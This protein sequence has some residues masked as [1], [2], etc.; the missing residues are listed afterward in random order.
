[1]QK[2]F[3]CM[4]F[5]VHYTRQIFQLN[6]KKKKSIIYFSWTFPIFVLVC[7]IIREFE[8]KFKSTIKTKYDWLLNKWYNHNKQVYQFSNIIFDLRKTVFLFLTFLYRNEKRVFGLLQHIADKYIINF[9]LILAGQ[10]SEI[11]RK[12]AYYTYYL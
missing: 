5:L 7:F 4:H 8:H 2:T 3:L 10:I 11:W 12:G 6:N 9:N 1:M